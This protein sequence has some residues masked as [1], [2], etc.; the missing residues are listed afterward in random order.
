MARIGGYG[1]GLQLVLA[2]LLF[3]F[4]LAFWFARPA[5]ANCA[6]DPSD[7]MCMPAGG[8]VS[9]PTSPPETSPPQTAPPVNREPTPTNA[10]V[11][12]ETPKATGIP[13]PSGASTYTP[14]IPEGTDFQDTPVL[15]PD[16]PSIATNGQEPPTGGGTANT[17]DPPP[18]ASSGDGSP[19]LPLGLAVG[20]VAVAVAPAPAKS[21]PPPPPPPPS[22]SPPPVAAIPALPGATS[23]WFTYRSLVD[24]HFMV[25]KLGEGGVFQVP[26]V[27]VFG[28]STFAA[29]WAFVAANA[30]D[31]GPY[32]HAPGVPPLGFSG[33]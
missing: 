32:F 10:P 2:G 1:R 33:F 7:P 23:D 25:A 3:A 15:P 17:T 31:S 13:T 5:A 18:P 30:V 20:A 26:G 8:G 22:P 4:A 24:N 14:P 21:A 12:R 28:P 9:N 16:T 19:L 11:Q 27:I 29:C 6:V